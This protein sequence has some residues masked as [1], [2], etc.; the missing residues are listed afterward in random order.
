MAC[1]LASPGVDTL[2]AVVFTTPERD[3]LING[4]ADVRRAVEQLKS[5]YLI[6]LHH[7]WHDHAL[8]YDPLFDFHMAGE[9]DLKE[10]DGV[11]VPLVPMDACNFVPPCFTPGPPAQQ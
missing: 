8:R 10:V 4:F 5:R 2:G 1:L 9:E 6:G 3:Q 11:S 7:N